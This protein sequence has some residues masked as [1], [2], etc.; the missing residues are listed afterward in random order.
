MKIMRS[1]LLLMLLFVVFTNNKISAQSKAT[2]EDAG[3][4]AL[5]VGDYAK[6]YQM[7]DE[8]HKKYPK[9]TDYHFKLGICALGVPDK[10]ERAIEIFTELNNKLK[11]SESELYLARAYHINYKFDEAL[12]ILEP[13]HQKL[14]A[15]KKKDDKA[16]DEDVL[17]IMQYCSSG[18]QITKM[19][20]LAKVANLGRPI[21]SPEIEGVP[22]ITGDETMMIFTYVGKKSL[23]GKV[24]AKLEKD[25]NG[26]YTSDIYMTTRKIDSAWRTPQPIL[27]LNTRANDAAVAL[28]P[29]G[30]TLFTFLST[31]ENEGDIYVSRFNGTV[32]TTPEPLNSNVNHP[33]FWEGSCSISADGKFL[34]FSS[35]RPEGSQGGR[36]IWVCE[37]IDGDWGP[38]KNLG[39]NINTPYDDDAP[40]IH[41]D[42][43]TLMFSSKG[44]N[45]IG[46]YDI[47]Y[48]TRQDSGWAKPKNMGMPLNTTEDDSYYVL[49]SKG[50]VGYFS[51]NRASDGNIGGQ[52]LYIVTPGIPDKKP[53]IAMFSGVVYGN[54]VPVPAKIE[55]LLDGESK[56][57]SSLQTNK[58]TGKYFLTLKP[59]KK[60]MIKVESDG[61]KNYEEA[62]DLEGLA[63]L[64]E[65]NKDIYLYSEQFATEKPAEMKATS[66]TASIPSKAV[67]SEPVAVQTPTV[68]EVKEEPKKVEEVKKVEEPVKTAVAPVVN[69]KAR[70][71]SVIKAQEAEKK[72]L[73]IA[74]AEELKV[75]AQK[76]EEERKAAIAA[77]AEEQKRLADEKAALAAAKAEEQ[78]KLAEEQK[79]TATAKAEEQKAVAAAKA[80]E[81]KRL[82]EEKKAALTAQEAE[83]KALV[84]AKAEEAKRVA[85]EKKAALAAKEAERKAAAVAKA[86]EA[87][88]VAEEKKAAAVAKAEERKRLKEEQAAAAMAAKKP[89]PETT[90]PCNPA[91]PTIADFKGKSLNDPAIYAEFIA[92][93]GNYCSQGVEFRVQIGAYR[94]PENFKTGRIA[95][96]GKIESTQSSDG[97]TRFTQRNFNTIKEAEKLR[98]K[99]IAKGIKDAWIVVFINGTRYTLEEFIAGDF[100]P[101]A[102][103]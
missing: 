50:D 11:S 55:V 26:S 84:A 41:P 12:K 36:D 90:E 103:N 23:G 82:A 16:L 83:K 73:A 4:E 28:S 10:K 75:Q 48:T 43:I 24:N 93:A 19:P 46:G 68:A 32:Y 29:D 52:D 7:F 85:E 94:H 9:E 14:M 102:I 81:Q 77:K 100:Q 66:K 58:S 62:I 76:K 38:A 57:M 22:V 64:L 44:H 42:G 92:A 35:E 2:L 72:A 21:N 33:D 39:P 65:E 60:Y 45:S 47:M 40:F 98:Q 101:K 6:A 80:E 53:I 70:Q 8:L 78:K 59:G 56:S 37:W 54:N 18:N 74:R 51:S 99:L 63:S 87:K 15:S 3:Y 27:T 61:F 49:N 25:P 1:S 13:L 30:L 34:Y 89:A 71:D 69:E 31:N 96:Y 67:V 86:E 88:R 91:M 97:I 5:N 95:S 17:H 20:A 79:A